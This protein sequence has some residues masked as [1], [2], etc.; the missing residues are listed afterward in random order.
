MG[1][2]GLLAALKCRTWPCLG[3]RGDEKLAREEG[4]GCPAGTDGEAPR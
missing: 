2:E 1:Q 3:L 4:T